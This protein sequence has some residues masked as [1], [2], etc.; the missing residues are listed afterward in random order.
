MKAEEK[1]LARGLRKKGW[2]INKIKQELNVSKSSVSIWVRNIELTGRQKQ[3]LFK[4]RRIATERARET[5][6][7]REKAKRQV[8]IDK[9][10]YEI[11]ALSKREL[12]LAGIALYWA[13]GSK[14]KRSLVQIANGDERVIKFIMRF[15]REVCKV[16][17]KKF[18][19]RIYIH[20]HLNTKRA[21]NYWSA[22]SNIP[23]NQFYKTYRKPNKSSQNKKDSLPYGTFTITICNTELFLKIKGWIEGLCGL[24]IK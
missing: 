2:S 5:R 11:S 19:G 15:Y 8:I 13:E 14:T 12:K 4:K 10:K 18:R 21:E 16:P 17:E 9:A 6:L 1:K 22:I 3:R 23:L 20:P 7:K 24:K